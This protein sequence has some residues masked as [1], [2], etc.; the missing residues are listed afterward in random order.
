MRSALEK[1]R[2]QP[3]ARLL[4]SK[5][6]FCK[7]AQDPMIAS[8]ASLMHRAKFVGRKKQFKENSQEVKTV[9]KR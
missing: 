6:R 1:S 7:K 9:F 2:R 3:E 5:V 8:T 4:P